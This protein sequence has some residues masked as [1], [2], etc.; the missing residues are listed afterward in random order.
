M[1]RIPRLPHESMNQ[2]SARL[3]A[4]WL[5]SLPAREVTRWERERN[6]KA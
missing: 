1:T 3:V 2:Y 5:A 6:G 4:A